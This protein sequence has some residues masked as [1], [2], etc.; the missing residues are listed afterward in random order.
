[1]PVKI[2]TNALSLARYDSK[3]QQIVL[4]RD[5]FISPDGPQFLSGA[6]QNLVQDYEGFGKGVSL[7]LL[8]LEGKLA[9]NYKEA[10]NAITMVDGVR[11]KYPLFDKD[12]RIERAFRRQYGMDMAEFKK[13][14]PTYDD[15]L[16]YKLTGDNYSFSGNVEANNV[17]KRFKMNDDDRRN[18]PAET[19]EAVPRSRQV[20]INKLS[21]L[22][23]YFTGP[24]DVI[25]GYI[26]D[27]YSDEPV[28]LK[29]LKERLNKA[30]L[31]PFEMEEIDNRL[32]RYTK[33]LLR[34]K[35]KGKKEDTYGYDEYLEKQD[36]FEER[37]WKGYYDDHDEFR[38]RHKSSGKGNAS[39]NLN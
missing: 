39:E 30:K 8:S 14:F 38:K 1:M 37:L 3:N 28:G 26:R 21:D 18:I 12:S 17:R 13:K 6:L 4:D 33:S 27:K 29:R 16:F 31:S 36:E 11:Q 23:K 34:D 2:V 15:Y 10:Q 32:D 24:L 25:N 7:R 19:T 5:I 35:I 22:E 20:T 9:N